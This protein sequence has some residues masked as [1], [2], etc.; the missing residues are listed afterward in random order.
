MTFFRS[1]PWAK[2][3]VCAGLLSGISAVAVG[4]EQGVPIKLENCDEMLN[5]SSPPERVVTVGQASTEILYALGLHD[6]V[7]GTSNWFTDVDEKYREVNADIERIADNFPSFEGVIGKKPDLV[8]AD[9]LFTI[10]PQGAVGKREQ[11]HSLGINTYVLASQCINQDGS[12]GIDGTRTAMFSLDDLYRNIRDIA[13]LFAVRER[14]KELIDSIRKRETAVVEQAKKHQTDGL[15][16]VF[17]YSSAAL[18]VDPWV[19]GRKTVAD[20]MMSTLGIENVVQSEEVWPMVGWETIAQANPDIIVVAEMSRRRF[21]G[22][23]YKKKL[24]FLRTD[25]VTK[26]MDAVKNNRVVVMDA[27]AMDVTLRSIDGLET[28]SEALQTLDLGRE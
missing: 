22:D 20:W 12:K 5:L 10:G 16:A 19:A 8:T 27:H 26:E 23:D 3:L 24:E 15:T 1:L 18:G 14:G 13:H 4:Q 11:F 9:F 17:W 6:R 25:P 21:E 2:T 28:L 7:A